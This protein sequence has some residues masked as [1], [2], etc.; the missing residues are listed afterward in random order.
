MSALNPV[1]LN[2][3][4][5]LLWSVRQ[6]LRGVVIGVG[7]TA[8]MVTLMLF[9]S[10]SALGSALETLQERARATGIKGSEPF[11]FRGRVGS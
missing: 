9:W 6:L 4:F 5:W 10:V 2:A 11:D 1:F 8:A 3:E 7:M